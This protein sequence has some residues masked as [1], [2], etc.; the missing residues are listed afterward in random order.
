MLISDSCNAELGAENGDLTD[1]AFS[2]SSSYD[3]LNVGPHHARWVES[4]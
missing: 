2:A 1:D 4:I 3:P